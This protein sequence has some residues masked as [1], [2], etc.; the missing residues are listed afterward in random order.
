VTEGP[1]TSVVRLS[2]SPGTL[3]LGGWCH[4]PSAYSAEILASA[5]FDWCCIDRQHGLADDA[6]MLGMIHALEGCRVPAVVRVGS[7]ASETIGQALDWGAQAVIVP[8]VNSVD[9]ARRAGAACRYPPDGCRSWGPSRLKLRG[10]H[11]PDDVPAPM[12]LVM[13]ETAAA[14]AEVDQ[15]ARLAQVGG[16]FV[17]PADLALAL[18]VSAESPQLDSAS[19]RVAEACREHGKL[20]GVFAGT[21]GIE[22]WVGRGFTWLAV[23][24]DSTLLQRAAREAYHAARQ[25][26]AASAATRS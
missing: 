25:S 19:R 24:S 18:G 12:C 22:Q 20:A 13:I 26:V 2:T 16:L 4:I 21:R 9:D 23:D 5:G 17:G 15:I 14:L 6:A 11:G 8:M 1:A 7:S 10:V 3:S